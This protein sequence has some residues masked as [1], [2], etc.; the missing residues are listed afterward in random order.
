MAFVRRRRRVYSSSSPRTS[1]VSFV[2][3]EVSFAFPHL[4]EPVAVVAVVERD[5]NPILVVGH[6]AS[7]GRPWAVV[8]R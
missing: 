7:Y 5:D 4:V 2:R 8:S 3:R 1:T 6:Q